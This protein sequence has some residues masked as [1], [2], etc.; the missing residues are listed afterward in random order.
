MT[1]YLKYRPQTIADLDL[2]SVRDSLQRTLL[3]DEI[4]HAFLFAGPKGT[5][6]TSAA[7]ILAKAL[8]CEGRKEGQEGI[9]PCNTCV[10]CNSIT[11]GENLDVIEIDAASHRGIDDIRSLRE[12]VK[13][14]PVSAKK[15]IYII[16][17]AH[18]LTTEACNALLKVLEEPP[19]HVIFV[20]ATTN[21]EKL[22]DTILSRTTLVQ[23]TKATEE[24]VTNRLLKISVSENIKVDDAVLRIIARGSDGAFRDGVKLF[25][26]ILSEQVELTKEGVN[27]FLFGGRSFN[28]EEFLAKLNKKD[29]EGA[30]RLIDHGSQQGLSAKNMAKAILALL[31]EKMLANT[32][33]SGDTIT[34]LE[35]FSKAYSEIPSAFIEQLPLE[36]AVVKWCGGGLDTKELVTDPTSPGLRGV[37]QGPKKVETAPEEERPIAKSKS[38]IEGDETVDKIAIS[39]KRLAI[40]STADTVVSRVAFSEEIWAKVLTEVRPRNSSTEALLRSSKPMM[41]DGKVLTVGVFYKFHKERLEATPHRDL[42]EEILANLMGQPVRITCTLTEPPQKVV[43]EEV[44]QHAEVVLT[45]TKQDD[46]IVDIAKEIF[47]S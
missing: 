35:L 37:E 16:D 39:D 20:L 33:E 26:Q 1:L 12:A 28:S 24:D 46:K 44:V 7:R 15:K 31:R 5:G 40:G 14:A 21:P 13:L 8:N 38:R 34:L 36:I 19:S 29:I 6:K 9:E 4:P 47:G 23:F 17:E 11:R 43:Q 22:I 18:M 27:E 32:K 30:L 45:E 2:K 3:Q 41:F 25:E 42:L 10:V